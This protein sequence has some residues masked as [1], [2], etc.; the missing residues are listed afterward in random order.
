MGTVKKS[1]Y[2]TDGF[3][4]ETYKTVKVG[5]K[6]ISQTKL[7]TSRYNACNEEFLVGIRQPDGTLTPGLAAQMANKTDTAKPA[8]ADTPETQE[9]SGNKPDT[10]AASDADPDTTGASDTEPV[11]TGAGG[12]DSDNPGAT[13]VD[14]DNS[15]TPGD[16]PDIQETSDGSSDDTGSS[17]GTTDQ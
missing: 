8:D 1:Q 16:D 3:V 17:G 10:A 5:D 4:V 6:V 7:H 12:D 13:N 11:D 14:P 2:G 9:P 15:K